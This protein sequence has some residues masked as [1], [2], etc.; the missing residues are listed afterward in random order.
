MAKIRKQVKTVDKWKKKKWFTLIAPKLFQERPL[1]GTPSSSNDIL[2]GRTVKVNLMT[3]MN[4]IK[5][6]NMAVEFEIVEVKGEQ[7]HTQVKAIALVPSFIKRRVRRNRDRIDA[8]FICVTKDNKHIRIK[9]LLI[10]LSRTSRL[11]QG[12]LR[13]AL[14]DYTVQTVAKMNY[15]E[16]VNEI[17]NYRFQKDVRNMLN[18]TYPVTASEIRSME[19]LTGDPA[20]FKIAT[21]KE[22]K[23]PTEE[24][25]ELEVAA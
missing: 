22:E 19:L 7:A 14:I 8:S 5:R 3:L 2:I 12:H 17:V 6:Q 4:N 23:N 16:F 21:V 10:T 25:A 11:I 15:D 9:P 13:Q 24:T 1:G 20:K 18:K